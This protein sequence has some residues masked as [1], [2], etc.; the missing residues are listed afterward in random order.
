MAKPTT[1]DS[2]IAAFPKPAQFM[3]KQLRSAIRTT[4]PKAQEKI[5]YGMPY[6]GY[7]GRLIYFSAFQHHIGLYIMGGSR[8]AYAKEIQQYQTS[9]ATLRFPIG[10]KIPSTLVKKLV[11][12]QMRENEAS[13]VKK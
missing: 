8:R 4:A 9:K 11:K 5:S 1:V 10:T 7:K 2:Y 6:Y 12:A 13:A 3:L